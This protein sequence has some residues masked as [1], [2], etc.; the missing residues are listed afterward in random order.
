MSELLT[1]QPETIEGIELSGQALARHYSKAWHQSGMEVY[2]KHQA[3]AEIVIDGQQSFGECMVIETWNPYTGT[4]VH[5]RAIT[6]CDYDDCRRIGS[7]LRIAEHGVKTQFPATTTKRTVGHA[8]SP[9][10]RTKACTKAQAV[11]EAMLTLRNG[12]PWVKAGDI[13]CIS[14]TPSD[15]TKLG[16]TWTV[17]GNACCIE[18]RHHNTAIVQPVERWVF[19]C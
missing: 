3:W 6:A 9:W 1:F 7:A 10:T 12:Y 14:T 18:L 19:D 5:A 4:R 8:L 15:M 16:H 11:N 17:Y 13:L 2:W